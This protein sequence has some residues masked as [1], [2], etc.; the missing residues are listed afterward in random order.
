MLLQAAK[1]FNI[2]LANS[3]MVGDG[4]NDVLAG[5]NAGCHTAILQADMTECGQDITVVSLKNFVD[6]YI[7]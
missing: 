4:A 5:K 1:D 6:S 2:D 7:K 3:W